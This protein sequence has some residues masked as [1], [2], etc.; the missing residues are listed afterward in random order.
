MIND[1]FL[2]R[3]YYTNVFNDISV[4]S[5][6]DFIVIFFLEYD[7][8]TKRAAR[9]TWISVATFLLFFLYGWMSIIFIMIGFVIMFFD[10]Y[11]IFVYF[12]Y[13]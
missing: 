1:I 7:G 8:I 13:I 2:T 4:K 9:S 6:D 12:I 11:L 5:N 3:K 10:Y